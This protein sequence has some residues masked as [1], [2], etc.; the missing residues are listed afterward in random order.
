MVLA[1]VPAPDLATGAGARLPG[2]HFSGG[3]ESQKSCICFCKPWM[4][5]LGFCR[6]LSRKLCMPLGPAK[7]GRESRSKYCVMRLAWLTICCAFLVSG[8]NWLESASLAVGMAPL[9]CWYMISWV[10]PLD[11]NSMKALAWPRSLL[12]VG[13]FLLTI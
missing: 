4:S 9:F 7:S 10:E 12:S 11:Q 1:R 8:E 6:N 2:N 3:S 13:D 5:P